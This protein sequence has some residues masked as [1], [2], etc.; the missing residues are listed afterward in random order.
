MSLIE[1]LQLRLATKADRKTRGWWENYLKHAIAFRGVPMA[2]I[3]T[4]LH[5][6]L[7]SES[8]LARLPAEK[9]KDLAI[10][11]MRE[12]HCEDKLAGILFL[13]EVLLP[14][15]AIRWRGDLPRFAALFQHGHIYEWN[16]CDWFCVKVLG[17][18]AQSH[19]RPCAYAISAWRGADNLWQRRAAGVA[20][21]NLA[22]H[23]D[24]NFDG[25]STMLLKTCA[26]MVRHT[27]RFAQ[28][29]AGWVLREL[30]RAEPER[31]AAF[32]K[33]NSGS[34]SR[35]GLSYAIAGLPTK[36]QTSLRILHVAHGNRR[37]KRV[38]S[39]RRSAKRRTMPRQRHD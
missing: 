3:R 39:A 21:V 12:R 29:G 32:V 4:E 8:I 7:K 22:K 35:E 17:P 16:T 38:I 37:A 20:F 36:T 31:V 14:A 6:W 11:L 2:D 10:G 33:A 15:D 26:A 13:Q 9:Q 28:T 19:G 25:F 27:E 1:K 23:G 5:Q 18:L 30:S 24:A 34:L